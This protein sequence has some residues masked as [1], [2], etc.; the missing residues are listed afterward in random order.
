MGAV[1]ATITF[2]LAVLFVGGCG[3]V[4]A[5]PTP[6]QLRIIAE[7]ENASVYV[8]ERFAASARR[9]AV[10]PHPLSPGLHRITV[11]APG[12]FPHDVALHL[13]AGVTTVEIALRPIPP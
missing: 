13:P 2:V 4:A 6:A 3:S 7:P 5:A 9:L 11:Q 1:T 10:R 12:Y 8:D